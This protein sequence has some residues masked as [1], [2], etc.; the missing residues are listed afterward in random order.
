MRAPSGRVF[1]AAA[2]C[3][4]D[5]IVLLR[6]RMGLTRDFLPSI[7]EKE[8]VERVAVKNARSMSP[9]GGGRARARARDDED[10]R[11]VVSGWAGNR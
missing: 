3:P 5:E 10:N 8:K 7:A 2:G 4:T 6:K 1:S 9:G 11:S